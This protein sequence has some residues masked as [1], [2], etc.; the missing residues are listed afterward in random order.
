[1]MKARRRAA[2]KNDSNASPHTNKSRKLVEDYWRSLLNSKYEPPL[3]HTF[4]DR[5]GGTQG[6]PFAARINLNSILSSVKLDASHNE[7]SNACCIAKADL[8]MCEGNY[9]EARRYLQHSLTRLQNM[10]GGLTIKELTSSRAISGAQTDCATEVAEVL[11]KLGTVS[12]ILD[13]V[14]GALELFNSSLDANPFMPD[15]YVLRASC[16]ERLGQPCAAHEEFEKYMKLKT[17]SLEVLAHCGK[18]AF[19]AG[20][21]DSAE[22][23]L[24]QLL[25]LAEPMMAYPQEDG[26]TTEMA[27]YYVAHANFYLGCLCEVR[28]EAINSSA[29]DINMVAF[30]DEKARVHFD[31]AL[32]NP[33]FIESYESTLDC[34]VASKDYAF[35]LHILH[36]LQRMRP[37]K[38]EYCLRV[39]HIHHLCNNA[40]GEVE[41]L[42]EALDRAQ[43][44]SPRRITLLTRGTVYSEMLGNF[45]RA[46]RDF[47]LVIDLPPDNPHDQCTPKAFMKRAE[48]FRVRFAHKGSREDY[49]ASL[50]D[51]RSFLQ[52]SGNSNG[53]CLASSIQT[54]EDRGAF[55]TPQVCDPHTITDALLILANGTFH[56]N[57]F[58]EAVR[59]FARAIN[60]G[61]CP[62]PPSVRRTLEGE[63]PNGAT[64]W[65]PGGPVPIK[66]S[67]FC[68]M[69]IALANHVIATHPISE[70]LFKV[71]YE[72]R[73]CVTSLGNTINADTK[74]I[75]NVERKEADRPSFASPSLSYSLVDARYCALRSL[76]PTMFSALEGM[77]L[78]IWEPYRTEVERVRE[79]M[80][81]AKGKRWK[82]HAN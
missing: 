59:Y 6:I 1:M 17:P 36:H 32:T 43:G 72:P 50:Q 42:S 3:Y 57:H 60:R 79:D 25:D 74:K 4:S 23:H 82:R 18:C 20:I 58:S 61:W 35:A 47:T 73:E 49:E 46:I 28:A 53:I 22:H 75:K 41:A 13:E 44:F 76:E 54:L 55:A 29:A 51:Y 65:A 56:R 68:E 11:R 38:A 77:F 7:F 16:Y 48:A 24:L 31:T 80:T 45:E 15:I 14:E 21:F 19:E 30:F 27:A 5:Y 12:L 71:N 62:R 52:T 34:A 8:A 78:K 40:L 9:E 64:H 66:E 37:D 33:S 67:L 10:K 69:Y 70:E 63:D 2:P 26:I 81:T 39:A